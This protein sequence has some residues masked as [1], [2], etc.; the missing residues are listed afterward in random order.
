M[1][2]A[3][4]ASGIDLRSSGIINSNTVAT[5]NAK[6]GMMNDPTKYGCILAPMFLQFLPTPATR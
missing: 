4:S 6:S 3:T 1:G 5:S 2:Q